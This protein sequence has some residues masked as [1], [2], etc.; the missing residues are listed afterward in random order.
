MELHA[1]RTL[2]EGTCGDAG[3]LNTWVNDLQRAQRS[4]SVRMTGFGVTP[5]E[6]L[7][8]FQITVDP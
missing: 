3:L 8:R 5:G 1:G 2:L 4:G 7:P 6:T